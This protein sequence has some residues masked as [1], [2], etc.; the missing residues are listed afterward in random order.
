MNQNQF[1]FLAESTCQDILDE[2]SM[3]ERYVFSKDGLQTFIQQVLQL[4]LLGFIR[5]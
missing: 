3:N 1:W 4:A 2:N 5:N